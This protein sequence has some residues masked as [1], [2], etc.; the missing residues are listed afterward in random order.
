M[1]I[2]DEQESESMNIVDETQDTKQD[3]TNEEEKMF[4]SV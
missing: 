4:L 3:C 2:D 1:T